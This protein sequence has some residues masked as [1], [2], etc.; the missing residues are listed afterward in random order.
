MIVEFPLDHNDLL[1]KASSTNVVQQ[2]KDTI[3]H[4]LPAFNDG[5]FD[6]VCVC[7]QGTR[8]NMNETLDAL[9][10]PTVFRRLYFPKVKVVPSRE[11]N[12]LSPS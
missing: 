7:S 4:S 12:F 11:S 8:L 5:K 9:M 2:L 3:M 1:V 10:C 6:L